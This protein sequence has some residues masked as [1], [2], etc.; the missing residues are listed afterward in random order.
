MVEL[1]AQLLVYLSKL[2]LF[3]FTEITDLEIISKVS[4]TPND[5]VY[6]HS[7]G[8]GIQIRISSSVAYSLQNKNETEEN[9]KNERKY[10]EEVASENEAL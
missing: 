4:Q 6:A 10:Q 7:S 8:I 9:K 2:S 5:I 1:L 3:L